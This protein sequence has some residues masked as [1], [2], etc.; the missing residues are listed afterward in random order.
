VR[1][2]G[3]PLPPNALEAGPFVVHLS[4]SGASSAWTGTGAL[5]QHENRRF[6][7]V[8]HGA[9]RTRTGDLLGAIQIRPIPGASR[10]FAADHAISLR[11]LLTGW[12]RLGLERLWPKSPL[13]RFSQKENAPQSLYS[14][15]FAALTRTGH[16]LPAVKSDVRRCVRLPPAPNSKRRWTAV[17]TNEFGLEGCNDELGLVLSWP[18]H[19]DDDGNPVPPLVL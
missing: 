14:C 19:P 7:A 3:S 16:E 4:A 1:P 10:R 2:T 18:S 8:S 12:E 5:F 13:A 9:S 11:G 6:A 17:L 15:G